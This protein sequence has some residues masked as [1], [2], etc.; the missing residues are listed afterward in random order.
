MLG[1]PWRGVWGGQA[2]RGGGHAARGAVSMQLSTRPTVAACVIVPGGG[3]RAGGG[4]GT[5]RVH[6]CAVCVPR[7]PRRRPREEKTRV[8]ASKQDFVF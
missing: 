6:W 3:R 4:G 1:G 8:Q 7:R 2:G 5:F